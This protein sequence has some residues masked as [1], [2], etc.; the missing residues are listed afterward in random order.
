M[1][2]LRP[3]TSEPVSDT[4]TDAPRRGRPRLGSINGLRFV[5]AF[6]IFVAHTNV[7][8][9]LPYTVDVFALGSVGV[10]FFFLLSGFVLT[11]A[12]SGR[13][14]TGQFYQRRFARLWPMVF[15]AAAL[16]VVFILAFPDP[17]LDVDAGSLLGLGAASVLLLLAWVPAQL[18]AANPV[19]WASSALAFF[20]LVFPFV[21]RP[22]LRRS[23]RQLAW[24]AAGLLVYAWL[25][26]IV[27][28]LA[29]PPP[30]EL[31]IDQLGNSD[32]LILSNYAPISRLHEFLFGMVVAAAV[33]KG[34]RGISL[35]SALVLLGAGLFVLWLFRDANWR[36][37]LPYDAM[38][39]VSL[40]LLALVIVGYAA[41]DLDE[42]PSWLRSRWMD[43]LG[44]WSFALL[45][46]HFGVLIQAGLAIYPDMTVVDFFFDPVS[47]TWSH[48]PWVVG[49]L[50]GSLALAAAIHR[51]YDTPLSRLLSPRP[52]IVR[53]TPR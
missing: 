17:E 2:A 14:T 37:A 9:P 13:N 5:A 47:P 10:T 44:T 4:V 15:L 11:W 35:R 21:V 25:L 27:V 50:I 45:L 29:Y 31:D 1:T 16:P 26:R 32:L 53:A 34:W 51:F 20:Y 42:M 52:P 28:W 22:V 48:L 36:I 18:E 24:I 46:F 23:L 12:F 38:N 8:L 33:R 43:R 6:G 40:P 39:Q 30:A 3:S 49:V 41:R 7:L 19:V